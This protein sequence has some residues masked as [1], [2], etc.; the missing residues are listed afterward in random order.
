[1]RWR[2]LFR[3]QLTW[4]DIPYGQP[5]AVVGEER[6]FLRAPLTKEDKDAIPRLKEVRS[7]KHDLICSIGR[8]NGAIVYS[9][10]VLL[11]D[12][13]VC[14]PLALDTSVFPPLLQMREKR[15]DRG[16]DLKVRAPNGGYY[17]VGK[18]KKKEKKERDEDE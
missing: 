6:L 12:D 7:G 4:K 14:I 13:A 18:G 16:Y 10:P 2:S 1:M 15:P 11:P 17:T 5:F 3:R 8:C 9:E